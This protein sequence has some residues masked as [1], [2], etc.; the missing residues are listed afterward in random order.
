MNGIHEVYDLRVV[1]VGQS[2][3]VGMGSSNMLNGVSE[4]AREDVR[5]V[6][7]NGNGVTDTEMEGTS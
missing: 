4:A 6:N 2:N 7:V 3:D 1:D 5:D